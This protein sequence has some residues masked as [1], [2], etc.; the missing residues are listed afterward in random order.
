MDILRASAA[1]AFFFALLADIGSA[2]SATTYQFTGTG[3]VSN[4][5]ATNF[6]GTVTFDVVGSPEYQDGVV[7]SANRGWIT[8]SFVIHWADGS[9]VTER[10]PNEEY[11]DSS[12][13]VQNKTFPDQLFTRT[14]SIS[15]FDPNNVSLYRYSYAE[16]NRSTNDVDWLSSTNFDLTKEMAPGQNASNG[17]WFWG[18]GYYSPSQ[19]SGWITLDSLTAPVPEP[20]EWVLMLAGLG[21]V[22]VAAQ[23]RRLRTSFA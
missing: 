5:A 19:T 6:W 1:A 20:H 14:Y 22:G 7:A 11:F 8:P 16:L 21:V 2:H 10:V 17:I 4:S 15:S 12:T 18:G 13:V 9:F 23:K 3:T